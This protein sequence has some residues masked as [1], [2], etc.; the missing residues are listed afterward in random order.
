M[1]G[2]PAPFDLVQGLFEGAWNGIIDS[3]DALW[4]NFVNSIGDLWGNIV[5]GLDSLWRSVLFGFDS[6]WYNFWAASL[7]SYE[8]V[9]RGLHNVWTG[10]V[11]AL[12]N[13]WNSIVKAIDNLYHS[14]CDFVL[15]ALQDIY[16]GL[17]SIIGTW[18]PEKGRFVGG[19]LGW[20]WDAISGIVSFVFSLFDG[21]GRWLTDC[22]DWLHSEV[23]GW[24]TAAMTGIANALLDGLKAIWTFFTQTLPGWFISA[25]SWVNENVVQPIL[26]GLQ[27][28]FDRLAGA[29]NSLVDGVLHLFGDPHPIDG[30]EALGIAVLAVS[31]A[32][33]VGGIIAALPDVAS[34]E[35]FGTGIR[36]ESIGKFINSILMPDVFLG[37]I[38]HPLLNEA[39]QQP[40]R[41]YFS[42][43]FR[44]THPGLNDAKSMLWRGKIDTGQYKDICAMAGY[45]DAYVD[46]F[47]ELSNN[48]PGPGDILTMALKGAF[49]KEGVITPPEP[50]VTYFKALG[51]SSD[52]AARFWTTRFNIIGL[53]D[54]YDNFFRGLF[55]KDDLKAV[56]TNN[57]IRPD[58]QDYI[59]RVMYKVP[60]TRDLGYGYD[61][62]LYS[63]DDLAKFKRW[64]GMS[65]DDAD[66]SAAALILFRTRT[67]R[68]KLQTEAEDDYLAGLDSEADL[69]GK[70]DALGLRSDW[71]DSVVARV[72]YREARDIAKELIKIAEDAFLKDLETEQ[73]LRDDLKSLGVQQSRIDIIIFE[74]QQRKKKAAKA[75]TAAKKANLTEAQ[76]AKGWEL[77]FLTD[78]NFIDRLEARNY[79]PE[80][81][82]LLLEIER[83]PA[84]LSA[85]EI[86]RRTTSIQARIN[87]VNRSYD[88][89]ILQLD[90][91]TSLISDE[92]QGV[93]TT[94][95][96]NLNVFDTELSFLADQAATAA[97][98]KLPK[99]QERQ[100]ILGA[101]RDVTIAR[102][103]QQLTKLKDTLSSI[104][105]RKM[106]LL[107]NRD[108]EI[109]DL[110]N[111]LKVI[112]RVKV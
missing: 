21:F 11:D 69:R 55:S 86:L 18:D 46:G 111:E 42:K 1:T 112:T 50:V 24:L 91:Q 15:A 94:M 80:D 93:Q 9:T 39:I 59:I 28:I 30:P 34:I 65:P 68:T 56:M 71:A 101:R 90:D 79:T 43:E 67:Y 5:G 36:T 51:F 10:V 75:A 106:Q 16:S 103:D 47:V 83:T 98:E 25:A 23:T 6:L 102:A 74:M 58:W 14:V 12:G 41:Y 95:T 4:T 37:M 88:L 22:F 44:P 66:K 100:A 29:A 104:A 61:A 57:G 20:L 38:L 27:W 85:E 81:A 105:D 72:K 48:L 92:I 31:A 70:L 33:T 84:P 7:P 54:A 99:I 3:V 97:P 78:I 73:D 13:L 40:L 26:G 45:R 76:V 49:T 19:F 109:T 64:T 89:M 96:E 82:Q 108:G 62:G 110:N 107:K 53:S 60:S 2:W 35:V 77:G 52:W 63:K 32:V 17:V 87:R 8:D